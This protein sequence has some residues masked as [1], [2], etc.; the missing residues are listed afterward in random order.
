M[1]SIDF[2]KISVKSK[3][4]TKKELNDLLLCL[5]DVYHNTIDDNDILP[6]EYFDE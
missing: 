1:N 3:I 2:K 5:T 4:C 6:D